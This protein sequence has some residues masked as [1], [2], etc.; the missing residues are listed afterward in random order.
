MRHPDR[1]YPDRSGFWPEIR[2]T[3]TTKDVDAIYTGQ[4]GRGG[5]GIFAQKL[6]SVYR[7]RSGFLN[8]FSEYSLTTLTTLDTVDKHRG[9]SGQ[10]SCWSHAVT[11]S[12]LTS[13]IAPTRPQTDRFV[14]CFTG[15]LGGR[16][17]SCRD[18]PPTPFRATV[19]PSSLQNMTP[20][21]ARFQILGVKAREPLGERICAWPVHEK[22][23][24]GPKNGLGEIGCH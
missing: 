3:L 15:D 5:Q 23:G 4:G 24:T 18:Y 14:Y 13:T 11:P 8:T 10:G 16:D 21:G 19:R 9:L 1:R 6:S 12:T 17:G 22:K 7:T 20:G 2:A